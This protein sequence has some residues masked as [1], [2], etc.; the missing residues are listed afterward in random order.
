MQDLSTQ[1]AS[2]SPSGSDPIGNSLDDYLRGIQAIVRQTNALSSATIPSASTTDIGAG[3]A[4]SVYITGTANITSF[5]TS[6]PG[7]IRE[8]RFDASATIVASSSI[9]LPGLNS[10]TTQGGD[11]YTFRSIGSGVWILVSSTRAIGALPIGGGTLTGSLGVTVPALGTTAGWQSV[12]L[13]LAQS[14]TGNNDQMLLSHYRNV[15]GADWKDVHWQLQRVVDS[16]QMG[17]LRFGGTNSDTGLALGSGGTTYG[18]LRSG[19]GWDFTGDTN[20]VGKL[21]STSDFSS[22]G[23]ISGVGITGTTIVSGGG[24]LQAGGSAGTFTQLLFTGEITSN[25]TYDP[26]AS[27]LCMFTQGSYGGGW[28]LKD[29]SNT[30]GIW[31]SFGAFQFGFGSGTG[32]ITSKAS[33]GTDGVLSTPDVIYTSARALKDEIRVLRHG[34]D[35][36]KKML[37]RQYVKYDNEQFKGKGKP[38]FGFIHD[39]VEAVAPEA[40]GKGVRGYGGV[41]PMGVLAIVANTVLEL[42]AR[43][44]KAGI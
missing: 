44:A 39:E 3:D 13:T 16:T 20:I 14:V 29:G 1:A 33:I 7:L 18:K 11:V 19:G 40:T 24:T 35:A 12:P 36:L 2:N 10:I 34:L 26:A 41:S 9:V 28:K 6:V 25:R 22:G 32:A 43:M 27:S 42:D 23:N 15:A 17:F 21:T 4:Q 5:G 8:C 31:S 37:P 30:L 38:E